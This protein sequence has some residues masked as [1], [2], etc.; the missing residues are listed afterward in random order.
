MQFF[1]N[2]D[3]ELGKL[4]F[5]PDPSFGNFLFC[6]IIFFSTEDFYLLFISWFE[7]LV[8]QLSTILFIQT[9]ILVEII[10][11][12]TYVNKIRLH[13]SHEK[14]DINSS[15]HASRLKWKPW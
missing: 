10:Y 15:L 7:I 11:F 14:S 12:L 4:M 9:F 13:M 8:Y 2:T 6:D 3:F 1:K 5:S